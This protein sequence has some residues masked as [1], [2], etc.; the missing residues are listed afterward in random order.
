M[1]YNVKQQA[2]LTDRVNNPPTENES[3]INREATTD[4]FASN[5]VQL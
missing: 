5:A 4:E 2:T 3:K 1:A